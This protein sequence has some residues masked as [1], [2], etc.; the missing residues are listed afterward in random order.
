MTDAAGTGKVRFDG[1]GR[2]IRG[3]TTLGEVLAAIRG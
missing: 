3:S 2:A 1:K